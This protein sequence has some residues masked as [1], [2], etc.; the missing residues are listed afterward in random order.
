MS[1]EGRFWGVLLYYL[2]ANITNH[3]SLEFGSNVRQ[4]YVMDAYYAVQND[5]EMIQKFK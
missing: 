1:D 4:T 2:S 3:S 5:R